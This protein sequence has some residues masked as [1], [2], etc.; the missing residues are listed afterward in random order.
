MTSCFD[1][2]YGES[3]NERPSVFDEANEMLTGALL[4]YVF[5]DLRE[6][7]RRGELT[8]HITELEPPILI[9]NV[10]RSIQNN[11]E[12][13]EKRSIDHEGLEERL[14]VLKDDCENMK[15]NNNFAESLFA[16]S[17]RTL[18]THFHDENSSQEMVHGIVVNSQRRRITVIFRGS[19]TK[20]DFITDAK[21]HQKKVE[22]PVFRLAPQQ[23]TE[24]INLH[25]GFYEYLFNKDDS[26]MSRFQGISNDVKQLLEQNPGFR[27]YCTGHSLGGALSTMCG[28]YLAADDGLIKNG[29]VTVVS[30]ASPLVGNMKFRVAF[31]ALERLKRLQH[32]RVSNKEDMVTVMPF[33]APKVAAFSPILA[34][35]AGGGNLYK[36]CGMRLKLKSVLRGDDV[37]PYNMCYTKDHGDDDAYSEEIKR[38]LAS[39][40]TLMGSFLHLA[41][42]NFDKIKEFHNCEEYEA[43][44]QT[45]RKYLMNITLDDLYNNKNIVGNVLDGD[46]QPEMMLNIA[47]KASKLVKS[48]KSKKI[49]NKISSL[50]Q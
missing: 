10:V 5:A 12:A 8:T 14:R 46:Y 40:K 29:P 9:D 28:F 23:T 45:C 34:V 24:T 3:N 6:M 18:L 7:S 20:K 48:R 42:R 21:C 44:L 41:K 38:A 36:H 31:Q 2:G 43:R 25:T 30:I 26:G 49:T 16:S 27:L 35:T 32:L 22:N 47:Q 11:K 37:Q 4:I 1:C 15:L 33:I 39:G 17:K 19:V 50:D 13:L